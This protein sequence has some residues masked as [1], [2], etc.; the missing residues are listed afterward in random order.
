M[1]FLRLKWVI[2]ERVNVTDM[3]SFFKSIFAI[4]FFMATGLDSWGQ[5]R[6]TEVENDA[7][8]NTVDTSSLDHLSCCLVPHNTKKAQAIALHI[9]QAK[10]NMIGW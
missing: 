7:L 10:T 2:N 5:H 4:S 6:E 9:R 8:Y 3:P 1:K